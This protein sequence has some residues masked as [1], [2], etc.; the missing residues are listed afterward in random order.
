MV[1]AVD[2]DFLQDFLVIELD[3]PIGGRTRLLHVL[4]Q[5]RVLD[6]HAGQSLTE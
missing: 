3:G 4:P 5:V 6:L 1:I 2:T